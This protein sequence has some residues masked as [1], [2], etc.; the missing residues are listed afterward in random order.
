MSVTQSDSE[1][2]LFLLLLYYTSKMFCIKFELNVMHMV[3]QISCVTSIENSDMLMLRDVTGPNGNT[4]DWCGIC[5][6]IPNAV[7]AT[8]Q[9]CIIIMPQPI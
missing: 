6:T 4:N 7:L 5:G 9:L 8:V 2:D 3:G 1:T